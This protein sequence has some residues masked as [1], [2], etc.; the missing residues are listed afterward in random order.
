[1]G[2]CWSFHHPPPKCFDAKNTGYSARKGNKV[3]IHITKGTKPE[4]TLRERSQTQKD[5]LDVSIFHMV[6]YPVEDSHRDRRAAKQLPKAHG[7]RTG[8]SWAM[9]WSVFELDR[10]QLASS[11]HHKTVDF[12]FCE[13]HLDKM[14]K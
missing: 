2:E 9:F 8:V 7:V 4:N 10:G 6:P 5:P 3:L 11:F 1:M 12:T 14:H 13:Y